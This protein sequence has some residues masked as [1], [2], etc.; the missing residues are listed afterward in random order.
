MKYLTILSFLIITS[1]ILHS[2]S[3]QTIN[4]SK[5]QNT[6]EILN[7][8]DEPYNTGKYVEREFHS[9]GT[10]W[11]NPMVLDLTEPV[12]FPY[13][14]PN[15]NYYDAVPISLTNGQI[16]MIWVGMDSLKCAHSNDGGLTWGTSI[17]IISGGVQLY[18]ISGI[19]TSSNRVLTVWRDYSSG[20]WLSYSDDNGSSWSAPV[21]VT[22]NG[23]DRRTTLTQSLDGKLWLFYD[24]DD[25][26]TGRDIYY[27][28]S[29]DDGLN[30]SSEQTFAATS[31]NES[32]GT[33]ISRDV[34]TLLAFYIDDSN[35]NQD[36]FMTSSTD[37]G[38]NWSAAVPIINSGE[39]E[40]W[41][42]VLRQANDDLWMIYII[43]N[44]T[45]I[46]PGYNQSDIYY[47]QS[48]D[49]GN[50]WTTPTQ[51]TQYI[52]YDSWINAGLVNNQ[53]FVTFCSWRWA[54]SYLGQR[55]LW[56]GLIGTTQDL[57][58]PPAV[59]DVY[60]TN[61]VAGNPID[62]QTF[63]DDETAV[64][65]VQMFYDLNGTPFGPIQMYD[66]GL[67][68][69]ENPGDNIWG[70]SIGPFQL[71]DEISYSF[72]V[73]DVSAN[74]INVTAGSFDIAPI[75]DV[76]NVLLNFKP[77]SQL[78]DKDNI[79]GSNAY[80]PRVNGDDY[81]YQGG[82]W[83]G[84]DGLGDH[85]V[86]NVHYNDRDWQQTPGSVISIAP[87]I[88]DQDGSVTYDDQSANGP[89]TGLQVHQESYQ[90]SDPTRDDFIIFRYTIT[91][92]GENG[93]LADLYTTL[94]SDP[95]LGDPHIDLG[96]YDNQRGLIYLYDSQSNPGGYIGFK[97]LGTGNMPHTAM[98]ERPALNNDFERFNYMTSGFP[99]L[100]TDPRD[101]DMLLTAQPFNLTTGSSHIIA[102][103][104]VMGGSLAELQENA[105]TMEVIYNNIF[106]S[107][108]NILVTNTDDSG[109]G[110]L[111][112]A[113]D[114]ANSDGGAS[115]IEFDPG[116]M[117][118]TILMTENELPALIEDNTT[119]NGDINGDGIP[120]IQ[121]RSSSDIV[122]GLLI[123]SANNTVKGLIINRFNGPGG[124]GYCG[125][126][127]TGFTS[128]HNLIQGCYLGTD[129]SGTSSSPNRGGILI[130]EGAHE[131]TIRENLFS[132]NDI[133]GIYLAY[134]NTNNNIV[135]GN[136][137]GVD[138]SSENALPNGNGIIIVEGAS[139]NI[140]GGSNPGEANIISFN[141]WGEGIRIDPR[142]LE[143]N[144]NTV[145]RNSITRNGDK[146]IRLNEG[147][148]NNI[149]PP[150]INEFDGEVLR[151]NT[152]PN[153]TVEIFADV[154]DEGAEYLGTV[155]SDND[156]NF[157][158]GGPFPEESFYNATVTDGDGNTSEFA[159][160][161]ILLPVYQTEINANRWRVQ[162][163]NDASYSRD[164]MD[165]VGG[166]GGEFPKSSGTYLLFSAGQYLGTIKDE[167][168]SVSQYDYRGSDYVTGK[169]V[170][171]IPAPIHQLQLGN[172][173]SE[174]NRVFVIDTNRSG[175]D[176]DNWPVEYGAP[177]D[178]NGDPLLISQQDSWTVFNDLIYPW[179]SGSDNPVLGVEMQRSTYSY[180][181]S[182]AASDVFFVKWIISNKSNNDYPNTY[183]GA[184]FDPDVDDPYQDL[185][186]T[187]TTLNLGYCYNS[188]N[189]DAPEAFGALLIKGPIVNDEPLKLTATF[190]YNPGEGDVD[191]DDERYNMLQ[192][193][194]RWGNEKPYGPFDY[195]GDPLTNLGNLDWNPADKR[196]IL[197]SGPF[198][199]YA[200]NVQ[201]IVVACIG[202]VGNN[203]LDAVANLKETT[204]LVQEFYNRPTVTL[205]QT[206][207]V[208]TFKTPVRITLNN[209][210]NLL[211]ADFKIHYDKSKLR[212]NAGDVKLTPLTSNF[213][214]SVNV[215]QSQGL[216]SIALANSTP[217]DT[218]LN[219]VLVKLPFKV[220]NGASVGDISDLTFIESLL[221]FQSDSLRFNETVLI[222]GS[223]EVVDGVLFGDVN[224][225]GE[226]DLIDVVLIL[227]VLVEMLNE[228]TPFQEL[229]ADATQNGNV[230]LVDALI[231]LNQLVL[232]KANSIYATLPDS[233]VDVNLNLPSI[234]GNIG[235]EMIV[236]L[237]AADM[238][239]L[240]GLDLVLAYDQTALR[241]ES[242]EQTGTTDM[243][244]SNTQAPGRV[245]L[246]VI[247]QDGIGNP[248][249]DLVNLVFRILEEGEH[250]LTV[251]KSEGV[252]TG[253][254]TS[255]TIPNVYALYQ[256]YPNP[257]NPVTRIKYDLP[258]VSHVV[259]KI[260]SILGEE[261]VTIINE[262]KQPG[263]HLVDYNASALASGVYVYRLK[264]ND[265]IESKKMI[266]LK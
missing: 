145:T 87:G 15:V 241:L 142:G 122:N 135:I 171:E 117:G 168:P 112:D 140:I 55:Q 86:M 253:E 43:D 229:L 237:R 208:N 259:L 137:I 21:S 192:G 262:E 194:D 4:K 191:N 150:S 105:D 166:V 169:I 23:S 138:I 186:G 83:I 202:A 139:N 33:V 221:T 238:D 216:V 226:L 180:T 51:F 167:T 158:F 69:D 60:P 161:K 248:D 103:G 104:L 93:N 52:G 8:S 129:P 118:Q 187:D 227:K 98:I 58:P 266:L 222:S 38:T 224:Q 136:Y 77:N 97:L 148:N 121:I 91:N 219:G 101:Y 146:G 195:T 223:L 106:L 125:I 213:I 10:N 209:V 127:L 11:Q 188:D 155:Q 163:P 256:N 20:L 81:L 16:L 170:N 197:C 50:N 234:E 152:I 218:V 73:A 199:L 9:S 59:F 228:V 113:I 79:S 193:L 107:G 67:H 251:E 115:L 207:G 198:T 27:R 35:G 3:A 141:S 74:T 143:T 34:S 102:F 189:S 156:G 250:T 203:R 53:P 64:S 181:L 200:G 247:N 157:E 18:Y 6:V 257:F 249:G 57:N 47:T 128:H 206:K 7:D 173:F 61:I 211:G 172:M 71:G 29:T 120:D 264:A 92:T 89:S 5:Y 246:A 63:V 46:L 31:F 95:D 134:E 235:Q 204:K 201:E 39:N 80:W 254:S 36:I 111:R 37:G 232:N 242:V 19:Q 32:F 184:W 185:I 176:W 215:Q 66:D 119:I 109:P 243:L 205:S 212:L 65:D 239:D 175:Y 94:W 40:Y 159:V 30:W 75:H 210:K 133:Y 190:T 84:W 70:E 165:L 25:P 42:R 108:G 99:T 258:E 13:Q 123:E 144:G 255:E 183:F 225:N 162:L 62:F 28:T 230:N 88:S 160:S 78:A 126:R 14:N 2:S 17:E 48:F 72:S 151:G 1:F 124:P 240:I 164:L 85:R 44:P 178:A 236:P 114:I 245:Y 179:H 154:F 56:Y 22:N 231:V 182:G 252:Q 132:G 41:P 100:P 149:S 24:R 45:P 196:L 233:T 76:G 214:K 116:L 217:L 130:M 244:V 177:V 265:Y 110:S 68:N 153:A 90:W 174:Q 261:V 263:K 220:K 131:N 147:A 82:L 49:G 260:Y 26:S 54:S 12:H 96:G